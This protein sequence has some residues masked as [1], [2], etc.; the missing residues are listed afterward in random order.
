MKKATLVLASMVLVG[1]TAAAHAAKPQDDSTPEQRSAKAESMK[2]KRHAFKA[3]Q[4]RT[5]SQANATQVRKPGGAV[6]VRVPEELW[7]TMAVQRDA[8]GNLRVIETDG[9]AAPAATTEGL[10]N[11]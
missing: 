5:M 7:S 3:T 4:P 8:N 1:A 9:T 2:A 10:P 6:A 11:E